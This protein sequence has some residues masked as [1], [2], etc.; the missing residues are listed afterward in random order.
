MAHLINKDALVAEIERRVK[1]VEKR[2]KT[3]TSYSKHGEM[4]W[5]RDKA[6]YDAYNSLLSSLDTLEVKGVDINKEISQFID[7]NF[8]KATNQW[9][10]VEESKECMYSKENYTDEDRKALCD[11]C[12]EE[13]RFNKKEDSVSEGFEKALA[14]EWQGYVDRGAATVDALEDNTQELAFAKGFYRGAQW[15]KEQMMA[16]AFPVEIDSSRSDGRCILSGNFARFET[17]DKVKVIVI[18]DE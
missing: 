15:Q 18:K 13:C 4:A 9:E 12:E 8:E 6:L 1:L 3:N 5:E 11:G 10:L 17:G 16:K 7:A 2:L 14:E